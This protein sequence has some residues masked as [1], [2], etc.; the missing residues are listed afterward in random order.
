[1]R[2]FPSDQ[3][4]SISFKF[5]TKGDKKNFNPADRTP[6]ETAGVTAGENAK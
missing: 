4:D 3:L 5:D 6:R 1:M 2:Q